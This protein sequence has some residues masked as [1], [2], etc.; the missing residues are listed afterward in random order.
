V[1]RAQGG[2]TPGNAQRAKKNEKRKI[3]EKN[4]SDVKE[5]RGLRIRGS[6]RETSSNVSRNPCRKAREASVTYSFQAYN[7]GGVRKK[8]KSEKEDSSHG[9]KRDRVS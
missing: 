6:K 9:E 7:Q 1:K 5:H 4:N 2:K 8:G 3:L